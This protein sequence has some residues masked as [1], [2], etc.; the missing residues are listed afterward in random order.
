MF[1]LS[2][3]HGYMYDDIDDSEMFIAGY[4]LV[5]KDRTGKDNHGGVACFISNT[6][7]L[8]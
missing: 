2:V 1:L 7:S 4:T 5:R 3:K 8:K 6:I